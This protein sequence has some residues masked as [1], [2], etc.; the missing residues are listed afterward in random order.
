MLPFPRESNRFFPTHFLAQF[1]ARSDILMVWVVY[2]LSDR[3]VRL[4]F[5]LTG[6]LGYDSHMETAPNPP[7]GLR[8]AAY[9]LWRFLAPC[10][11]VECELVK[12]E[13][14]L[15]SAEVRAL[16]A[17][18][19]GHAESRQDYNRLVQQQTKLGL[20][21]RQ[22]FASAIKRGEHDGKDLADLVIKYLSGGQLEITETVPG[23]FDAMVLESV[24]KSGDEGVT[25]SV[26]TVACQSS[27]NAMSEV[28]N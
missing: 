10:K 12:N 22:Q 20:F 6:I 17:Q 23:S 26:P 18:L 24:R 3:V 1:Q 5:A 27:T 9:R 19:A 11:C 15:R 13:L 21:F 8:L 4:G 14:R 28:Q 25:R 7:T 2:G 16:E